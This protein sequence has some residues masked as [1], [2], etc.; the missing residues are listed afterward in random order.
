MDFADIQSAFR[1][2]AKHYLSDEAMMNYKGGICTA[3]TVVY[4]ATQAVIQDTAILCSEQS[5]KDFIAENVDEGKIDLLRKV[6]NSTSTN[7]VPPLK[8]TIQIFEDADGTINVEAMRKRVVVAGDE[9]RGLV[10]DISLYS[11]ILTAKY[12]ASVSAVAIGSVSVQEAYRQTLVTPS[13]AKQFPGEG[14]DLKGPRPVA[15]GIASVAMSADEAGTQFQT[16]LALG[17][18]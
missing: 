3:A 13:N 14:N 12:G 7:I 15:A 18:Y 1:G 17:G 5:V 10:S 2:V 4:F 11:N 8:A 16:I 9:L 6:A